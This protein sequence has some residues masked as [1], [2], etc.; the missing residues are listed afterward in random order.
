MRLGLVTSLVTVSLAT[1]CAEGLTFTPTSTL[2][3]PTRGVALFDEA[4]PKTI[5][6]LFQ[7]LA[8]RW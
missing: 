4:E 8:L 6:N 7:A 5:S 3:A 1:G 2:Y